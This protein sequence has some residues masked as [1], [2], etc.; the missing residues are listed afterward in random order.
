MH[1]EF[2]VANII[3]LS[4]IE[5]IFL[6][7]WPIEIKAEV[8]SLQLSFSVFVLYLLNRKTVTSDSGENSHSHGVWLD[9]NAG[10]I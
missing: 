7:N 2:C 3:P 10:A 4:E 6:W 5:Q 9:R 1:H 8:S